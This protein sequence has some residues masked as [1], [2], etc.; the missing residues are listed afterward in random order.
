MPSRKKKNPTKSRTSSEQAPTGKQTRS[1]FTVPNDPPPTPPRVRKP[2]VHFDTIQVDQTGKKQGKKKG[3]RDNPP[4]PVRLTWGPSLVPQ[5]V[6][7]AQAQDAAEELEEIKK[8]A[9][10]DAIAKFKAQ[11]NAQRRG[12]LTAKEVDAAVALVKAAATVK[13]KV[14]AATARAR[15]TDKAT[16][17]NS[18]NKPAS[19]QPEI[20][21]DSDDSSMD[22][23]L[24][25]AF[26]EQENYEE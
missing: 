19:S 11:L 12:D 17:Q 24:R 7:I 9:A 18:P 26:K 1:N 3:K 13:A 10:E 15:E 6:T 25:K 14:K 8:K 22:P 23:E 20:V 5:C 2:T 4:K 21:K 16:I